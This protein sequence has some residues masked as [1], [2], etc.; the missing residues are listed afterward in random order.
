MRLCIYCIFDFGIVLA[1]A[2]YYESD[3]EGKVWVSPSDV[4]SDID[5]KGKA[6]NFRDSQGNDLTYF[7]VTKM[8]KSKNNGIDHVCIT[9]RTNDGMVRFVC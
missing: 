2:F 1:D 3:T 9:S 4:L 7:G 5:E 6:S 8:S